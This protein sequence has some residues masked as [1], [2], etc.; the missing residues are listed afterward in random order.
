MLMGFVRVMPVICV[1]VST[2]SFLRI[3]LFCLHRS[4]HE[5][6]CI[7]ALLHVSTSVYGIKMVDRNNEHG[8]KHASFVWVVITEVVGDQHQ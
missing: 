8:I 6:I 3:F 4:K 2:Y 5:A 7:F 1:H